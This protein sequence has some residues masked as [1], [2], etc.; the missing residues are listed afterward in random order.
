MHLAKR[1]EFREFLYNFYVTKDYFECHEVLEDL[2]KEIAPRDKQHL[3][4]GFVL[5]STG[6]YHWRRENFAGAKRSLE[7]AQ[8]LFV[9]NQQELEKL[10]NFTKLVE[11][12]ELRISLIEEL[13]AYQPMTFQFHEQ[14]L[15]DYVAT[16]PQSSVVEDS[17]VNRHLLRDRSEVVEARLKALA[18]RNK[19]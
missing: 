4:V 7:K 3:V 19:H 2:W 6:L 11:D 12:V 16:F 18:K 1:P 9:M 8:T 17:I 5:L 10:L 14:E 13:K 15:T